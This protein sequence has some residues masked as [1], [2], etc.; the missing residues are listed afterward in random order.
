L[1]TFS[2]FLR[3]PAIALAEAGIWRF[4]RFNRF[5]YFSVF[6]LLPPLPPVQNPNPSPEK[7]HNAADSDT[8]SFR[9]VQITQAFV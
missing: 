5:C 1:T 2:P 7:T 9:N 6:A 4:S 8:V 3:L